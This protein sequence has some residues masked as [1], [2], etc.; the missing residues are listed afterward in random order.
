MAPAAPLRL[1]LYT[2]KGGVGKTTTAAA[3]AVCAAERGLRT[4]IVSADAAHSLGDVL[5]CEVGPELR[6]LAPNLVAVEIDA[7]VEMARHWG[8]IRDYL[9]SLFRYQ[10]IEDVVAEELALLPGAEELTTL[11]AV[12][13][14]AASGDFDFVV[15]DCAPTDSTL[16]LLTL[17]D[18]A[19]GTLRVLLKLQQ[20][21][22]A[23]ITPLARSVVPVPLPDSAVFRDAETLLYK[24]LR[25]LRRR[26][27]AART[28]V[29]I[30]VTPERMVIDESRRAFTDLCLFDVP[31][32]A[33]VMNR[34]LPDAVAEEEFFRD[35]F[36]IQ[37]ERTREVAEYFAPLHLLRAPLQD[38]EVTGLER[39]ADH[40]RG[41]FAEVE[42]DA[43]LCS[44]PR[45]RFA[46]SAAGYRA[47]LPLPG[48]CADD[49]DV[50]VVEDELVVRAGGRRRALLLPHRMASLQVSGAR[51]RDGELVVSFAGSPGADAEG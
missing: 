25:Q 5:E 22:S 36:R 50:A 1:V 2:G 16:R 8:R 35:W 42:P 6:E 44:A 40:G 31:C 30:V 48:A 32:D 33:V 28:S 4:G 9:V 43:V 41:L 34:L 45:V 29:R 10:G 39:L 24:R 19:R 11:L 26:I 23:L 14:L 27:T 47:H 21:L 38:D 49:L 51:L 20:A 3:T 12:E 7:R 15:V 17:P 18:V 46:R 13:A 37:E